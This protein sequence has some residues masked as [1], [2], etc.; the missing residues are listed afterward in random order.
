MANGQVVDVTQIPFVKSILANLI[1]G[2]DISQEFQHSGPD[3]ALGDTVDMSQQPQSRIPKQLLPSEMGP[4]APPPDMQQDALPPPDLSVGQPPPP[5]PQPAN[6]VQDL[7]QSMVQDQTAPNLRSAMYTANAGAPPT[8][9]KANRLLQILRGGLTGGAAGAGQRTFGQGFQQAQELPLQVQGMQLG[10]QR[11]GLENRQLLMRLPFF[12]SEQMLNMLKTQGEIQGMNTKQA[13]EQAQAAA[14][15][16]KT[17]PDGSLINVQTGEKYS[18]ETA[19]ITAEE[20]QVLGKN[21]GDRVRI[22][23]KNTASE[24]VNRGKTTINTEEGVYDYNRNTGQKTRL[25]AN[26]RN[27]FAPQNRIIQVADPDHPGQTMYVTAGT[28]VNQGYAGT[29]S[30]SLVVPKN[31]LKWATT[32]EGGKMAG[33]FNTAMQH[34]DLL[35]QALTALGNGDTR[36]LNSMKNSFKTAFGSSDMTNFQAIAN[37]YSREITKMLSAGHLTDSEISSA[38]ATLPANASPEQIQGAIQAYRALAGSKMNI[39]YDQ[40]QKGMKGQPNFQRTEQPGNF[41]VTYGGKLYT[42]KDQKS[43]DGFK[44]EVGIK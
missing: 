3:A 20:A 23:D 15:P 35:E 43:L 28:A 5:P 37:A 31:V 39:L 24:I 6:P 26:P 18:G 14:A 40:F 16:W 9:T 1:Q 44:G 12:R 7:T 42:F 41:S 8:P 19:P 29:Q 27:V 13:L 17:G 25:G 33:A 11:T 32:G 38:E 36:A 4:P 30:A 21:P 2:P 34:A 10:N 22:K